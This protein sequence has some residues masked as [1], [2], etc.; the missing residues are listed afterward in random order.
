MVAH[1]VAANVINAANATVLISAPYPSSGLEVYRVKEATILS[2]GE[3][4]MLRGDY[5]SAKR[6]A[7][8]DGDGSS[9]TRPGRSP[10]ASKRRDSSRGRGECGCR[11]RSGIQGYS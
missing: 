7:S 11:A 9:R 2:R 10:G 1:P 8:A 3:P 6:E 5:Y 4:T